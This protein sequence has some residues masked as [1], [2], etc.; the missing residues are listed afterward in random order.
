MGNRK[1]K[2]TTFPFT[3]SYEQHDD[4]RLKWKQLLEKCRM[5]RINTHLVKVN[6]M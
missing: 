2:K 6:K 3:S 1:L 5:D 4:W